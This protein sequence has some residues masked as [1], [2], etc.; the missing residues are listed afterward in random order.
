[1]GYLGKASILD[2]ATGHERL[3]VRHP[4]PFFPVSCVALSPDGR[5]LAT[6]NQSKFAYIWEV[7]S[8]R[9]VLKLKHESVLEGRDL[10]F[11]G[12]EY[13]FGAVD[14][15][16]FSPDSS[17]VATGSG[18]GTARIWDTNNGRQLLWV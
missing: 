16:T 15:V 12:M 7:I 13:L 11:L 1:M 18:D 3:S 9:R 14:N 10:P 8:G 17:K 5:W 6:G 4:P 2:I